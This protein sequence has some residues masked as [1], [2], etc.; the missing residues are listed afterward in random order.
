M[1]DFKHRKSGSMRILMDIVGVEFIEAAQ[2]NIS[3]LADTFAKLG[4]VAGPNSELDCP[5]AFYALL[6]ICPEGFFRDDGVFKHFHHPLLKSDSGQF[7][8]RSLL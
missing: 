7:V 3:R 1:A 4:N 2:N 8:L 5:D 6:E